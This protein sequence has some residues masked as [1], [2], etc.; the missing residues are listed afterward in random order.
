MYSS[1]WGILWTG[2]IGVSFGGFE[3]VGRG[4]VLDCFFDEFLGDFVVVVV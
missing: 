1:F 3:L 2:V 4:G